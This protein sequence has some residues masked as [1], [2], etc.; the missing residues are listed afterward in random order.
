MF[1]GVLSFSMLT[2]SFAI[3]DAA[4]LKIKMGVNLSEIK[5]WSSELVFNDV[6]KRARP[7]YSIQANTMRPDKRV[8]HIDRNG[9]IESLD[10]DQWAITYLFTSFQ[11]HL[12]H[13]ARYRCFY[14]GKGS[15]DFQGATITSR[16]AGVIDFTI[17][18]RANNLTL[19]IKSTRLGDPIRNIRILPISMR[20]EVDTQTYRKDFLA[21]W[22]GFHAIRFMDWMETNHTH[23]SEWSERASKAYFSQATTKGV[24]LEYMI[25]LA[26]TLKLSPWFCMPYAASDD[27]V[28]H[29]ANY[30]KAHLDPSLKAYV[31]YS[32]EVWNGMFPSFKYTAKK[33]MDLG[34][35]QNRIRA[36]LRYYTH[37]SL[38]IFAIW[39]KVFGDA[40]RVSRVL[41]GQAVV[42]WKG[43]EILD[44]EEAYKHTD[45]FAIAPYFGFIQQKQPLIPTVDQLSMRLQREI[46]NQAVLFSKYKKI[47]SSRHIGLVAY[48][49]GQHLIARNNPSLDRL[50]DQINRNQKMYALYKT[51]LLGWFRYGG[52][53]FMHFSS[54]GRYTRFGRWGLKEWYDEKPNRFS[55]Y[56]AVKDIMVL[57]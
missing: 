47:T 6:F 1:L 43:E 25:E 4:E 17:N 28:Y 57:Q 33:G 9:W 3:V 30:V 16:H 15:V 31:E 22:R 18:Q 26:N 19:V 45:V 52:G 42:P 10:A 49:G 55:K 11:G 14:D 20:G 29:F 37:R 12:P 13:H 35:S 51:Y 32:N 7:W 5:D 24:A 46:E 50:Y 21:R 23:V 2:C 56:S 27:Y 41:A 34:L 8:V 40:G 39:E 48:E 44:W 36:S 53:V 38:E 54:V